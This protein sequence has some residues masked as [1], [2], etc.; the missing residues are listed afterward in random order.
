MALLSPVDRIKVGTRRVV[1]RVY[2]RPLDTLD[3]LVVKLWV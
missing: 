3:D 1:R 2:R